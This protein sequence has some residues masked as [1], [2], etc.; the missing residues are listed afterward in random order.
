MARLRRPSVPPAGRKPPKPPDDSVADRLRRQQLAHQGL[1]LPAPDQG[2][3]DIVPG[4]TCD[5]HERSTEHLAQRDCR[6]M[7]PDAVGAEDK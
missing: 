6:L 7:V 4:D 1:E 3:Q 5:R 2:K